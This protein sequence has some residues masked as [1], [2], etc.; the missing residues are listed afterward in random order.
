MAS[1]S[2]SGGPCLDAFLA[3]GAFAYRIGSLARSGPAMSDHLVSLP[4]KVRTESGEPG[5]VVRY[6]QGLEPQPPS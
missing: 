4:S 5:M 1:R 3:A 2:S 6:A